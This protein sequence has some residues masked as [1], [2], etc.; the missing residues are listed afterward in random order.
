[1]KKIISLLLAFLMLISFASCD[2]D[3]EKDRDDKDKDKDKTSKTTKIEEETEPEATVFRG[4]I[5]T[6]DVSTSFIVAV[7]NDGTVISTG[8]TSFSGGIDTGYWKDVVKVSAGVN[9]IAGLTSS[10]TVYAMGYNNHNRCMTYEWTDIIDIHAGNEVTVGLKSDGTVIATG[11]ATAFEYWKDVVSLTGL[12]DRVYGLTENGEVYA[13]H[14]N[15]TIM[16]DVKSIHTN[17]YFALFIKNDGTVVGND[18]EYS[19]YYS[20]IENWAGVKDIAMS[21]CNLSAGL[22]EDGTVKLI[23]LDKTVARCD[24]SEWNDIVAVAVGDY[25]VVGLKSDGTVVASGDNGYGQCDVSEWKDVVA[26]WSDNIVTIGLT[27]DGK[28]LK[29]GRFMGDKYEADTWTGIKTGK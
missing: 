24:V 1:M 6:M 27:E 21:H 19:H 4:K 11:G 25:H 14:S 2:E 5:D 12:G 20:G 28:I 13:R 8:G 15:G 26:I 17:V 16:S 29:A 7:K 18:P 10:G 9:H 3:T 23:G 22:M